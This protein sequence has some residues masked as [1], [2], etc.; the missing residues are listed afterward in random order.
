MTKNLEYPGK[1]G[2]GFHGKT[3]FEYTADV[4]TKDGVAEKIQKCSA[5]YGSEAFVDFS[6]GKKILGKIAG[7]FCLGTRY[8]Y[9]AMFDNDFKLTSAFTYIPKKGFKLIWSDQLDTKKLLTNPKDGIDYN[10]GF[11]FEMNF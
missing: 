3:P 5:E 1:I 2:L 11:T 10:Y 7:K 8:T 6:N 4:K 9:Q